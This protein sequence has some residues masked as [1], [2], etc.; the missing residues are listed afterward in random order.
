MSLLVSVG[1]ALFGAYVGQFIVHDF[2]LQSSAFVFFVSF[3][4]LGRNS[5]PIYCLTQRHATCWF[6]IY[7]FYFFYFF[8][9]IYIRSGSVPFFFYTFSLECGVRLGGVVGAGA[10]KARV[11]CD[12][13][14]FSMKRPSL[15]LQL[16]LPPTISEWMSHFSFYSIYFFF[17]LVNYGVWDFSAAI[18]LGCFA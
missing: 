2:R 5:V 13:R 16:L 10:C 14:R 11:F 18:C 4:F 1:I 17:N 3:W 12:V 6:G 9:Y 7:C 8:L 15:D